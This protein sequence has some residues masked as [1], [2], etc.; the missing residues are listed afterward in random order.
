MATIL[1]HSATIA[2]RLGLPSPSSLVGS[3][4][5]TAI[6]ILS[7]MTR[8]GQDIRDRFIWPELM[9]EYTFT[10]S[11]STA[12]YAFPGDMNFQIFETHWN[13]TQKWPLMGPM[14]PTQWQGVK[15]GLT[16]TIA[17]NRFRI[18]GYTDTQFY[19]D[20]TPG[21]AESGQTLVFEYITRSWLKPKTWVASTSWSGIQYC[22]YNGN[23]YDRGSTGA[24]TTGTSAP[25]HT[26]G[27][28]SDG[29]I[30][31]T[32]LSTPY[33]YAVHDSDQLILRPEEIIRGTCWRY[34]QFK[35]FDSEQDRKD[36]EMDLDRSIAGIQ[37][38]ST[39]D[40]SQSGGLPPYIGYWSIPEQDFGI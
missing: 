22:S 1:Q 26:S 8:A 27:S 39:W 30:T 32:Y 25:V 15:S 33:E 35:G 31:W 34:N 24:G 19:I 4:N 38:A 37:G 23:F 6:D 14:T 2:Q 13:R 10:L 28:V 21:S 12:A 20:P 17:R 18:K 3:T 29:G 40:F 7:Q 9:K 5:Q 36:S 16:A 11:S